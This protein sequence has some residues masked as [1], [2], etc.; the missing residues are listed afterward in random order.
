MQVASN[1]A[2]WCHIASNVP[3]EL[4]FTCFL[5]PQ[6]KVV[7]LYGVYKRLYPY[8]RLNG[9]LFEEC[10]ESIEF[11]GISEDEKSWTFKMGIYK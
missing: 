8:T 10:Y 11:L 7:R 2:C 5:I 3:S 6:K 9:Q 4:I 1:I